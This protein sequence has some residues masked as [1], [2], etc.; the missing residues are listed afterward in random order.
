MALK[1]VWGSSCSAYRERME[2][3]EI[4][5]K[6]AAAQ[7][8]RTRVIPL[9]SS[10]MPLSHYLDHAVGQ[11]KDH[12]VDT[13]AIEDIG[14]RL[15]LLTEQV[16]LAQGN[17]DMDAISYLL[18]RVL[19]TLRETRL[20]VKMIIVVERGRI[21]SEVIEYLSQIQLY[22]DQTLKETTAVLDAM[23]PPVL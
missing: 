15:N 10:R 13:T 7:T 22:T 9:P 5:Y 8:T 14:K 21:P 19:G 3:T 12:S 17:Q 2:M 20:I 16:C 11:L 4:L 1:R 23:Q 18:E 6:T